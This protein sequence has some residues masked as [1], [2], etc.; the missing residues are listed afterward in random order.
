MALLAFSMTVK[1]QL[2][3]MLIHL[4]MRGVKLEEG[5]C[6]LGQNWG[7]I[8]PQKQAPDLL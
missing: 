2:E 3:A 7:R 4:A 8:S 5:S 1:G 6:N